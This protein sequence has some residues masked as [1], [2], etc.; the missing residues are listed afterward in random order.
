MKIVGDF[1]EIK[2]RQVKKE[3]KT[4][5]SQMILW[6]GAGLITV[7]ILLYFLLSIFY[8]NHFYLNTYINNVNTSN[9]TVEDAKAA[10]NAKTASYS[11]ILE[12]R[13]D[14]QEQIFGDDFD[15]NTV[16]DGSIEQL[17]ETQNGFTWPFSFFKKAEVEV[18]TML[19]YDEALL[20][21]YF[22]ELQCLTPEYT[23]TP[24]NAYISEYGE[25]GYEIIPE[26][27]GAQINEERL[28]QAIVEAIDSLTPT[29]N[30]DEAGCYEVPVITSQ[31]PE[32]LQALQEATKLTG[33]KI[34]YTFGETTEILDANWLKDFITIDE[35][36]KVTLDE[37]GI[38]EFVDYIGKTYN[39]FGKTRTLQTSYG[40]TIE[41]TGGDY[42]WWLDRISEVEELTELVYE[43]AVTNREPVYF[44]TAAE[45]GEND[46]G[47][48]YVEVNLTAQHLFFYKDGE[49][50]VESDFVSGNLLKGYGTPVG[51]YPVQYKENDATLNGEDYSTPV[52]YW[53][54]F[55][56]NIGFHDATW[57][58]DFG[59]S[60]Y[61]TSGSH[62]CIN[63]PPAAAK[64][65]FEHISRGVGVYVY[66][67]PG[68]ENY[69]VEEA[70]QIM[71]QIAARRAEEAAAA[72]QAAAEAQAAA[73]EE[74]A[75]QEQIG[76]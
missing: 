45:Y 67:L 75:A 6:S 58:R 8:K 64:T 38:K 33:T 4:G 13:N 60:Y 1:M 12:E 44:Q 53:M 41:I 76:Q 73:D 40:Q 71:E 15:L 62:G 43:G 25:N 69:N 9:M 48:T 32:I 61:L 39:T 70:K 29:L 27:Q 5:P 30:L 14:N 54:P 50:I 51:T 52:K 24:V 3:K 47:D 57:R 21:K 23:V 18:D 17:M 34:T 35:N 55:N 42:G 19:E 56:R 59:K 46:V 22:N 63:M 65:M 37:T 7:L 26:N 68:T 10:I 2:N 11:L 66:E 74:A 16:F 72:A 36:Y 31:S 20:Q 28:Y 49:L